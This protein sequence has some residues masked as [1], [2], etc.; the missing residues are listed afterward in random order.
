M[1]PMFSIKAFFFPFLA[2]NSFTGENL[3]ELHVHGNPL[4]VKKII[5]LFSLKGFRH[6]EPGEFSSRA[7]RNK[8]LTLTQV[9]GLD[10][11]IHAES[12]VALNQGLELIDGDLGKR[13]ESLYDSYLNLRMMVEVLMDFSDDVGEEQ[14]S[15]NLKSAFQ[16]FSKNLRHLAS[17]CRSDFNLLA[18]S[19]VI[20]GKPNQGKSTFFNHVLGDDRSLVYDQPGTTRDFISETLI[21][22]DVKFKVFDTAGL[23]GEKLR[24]NRTVR[25][26]ES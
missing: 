25:D 14:A 24:R 11:L 17:R 20:Y 15:N 22:D 19:I 23:R 6:A 5:E 9:E 8:K 21:F 10:L 2:P 18:P 4:N 26:K 1:V 12:E 13:Y 3:A 16:A 7:L